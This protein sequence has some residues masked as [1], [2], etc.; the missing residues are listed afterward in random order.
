MGAEEKGDGEAEALRNASAMTVAEDGT[1]FFTLPALTSILFFWERGR[2]RFHLQGHA[3][4][5]DER[6]HAKGPASAEKRQ[7]KKSS[8]RAF[9]TS[10]NCRQKGT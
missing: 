3:I 5:L 8:Q 7:A 1:A 6:A 2:G 4:D 10:R 9:R